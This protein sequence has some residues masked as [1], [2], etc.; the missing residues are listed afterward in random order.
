MTSPEMAAY[1]AKRLPD[2]ATTNTPRR[3][4]PKHALPTKLDRAVDEEIGRA[5]RR[6]EARGVGAGGERARHLEGSEDR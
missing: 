5:R 2:M 1:L 4:T 3:A 6:T